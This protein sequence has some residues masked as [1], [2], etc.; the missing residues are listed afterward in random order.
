VSIAVTQRLLRRVARL[1]LAVAV[2]CGTFQAGA[3]YF[4]CEAL[5]L[6]SSDPCSQS[7][8]HRERCP[9]DAIDLQTIDCCSVITMPSM[10]D[11]IRGSGPSVAPA[12]VV[13]VLPAVKDANASWWSERPRESRTRDAHRKP[14]RSPGE[15]RAELMVFLT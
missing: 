9:F 8:E 1:I 4:Y 3:R 14:P 10:P 13:A 7:A 12:G 11:G 6:S 5:G 15:R 2:L